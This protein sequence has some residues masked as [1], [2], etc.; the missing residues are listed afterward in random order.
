MPLKTSSCKRAALR[1]DMTRFS[2]V[3]LGY[4]LLLGLVLILIV[5]GTDMD[6]WFYTN[7]A[8]SVMIMAVINCGYAFVTAQMLFGD[9]FNTRLCYG[10]H[11]LPLKREHWY[12]AHKKAGM[13]FSL[14]PTAL[15]TLASLGLCQAATG[16]VN[17]WQI[18][19][20]WFAA[21]NLQYL[22]FFG[23]A[24]FCA[25]CVGNRFAM[26]VVYAVIN[27][28]SVLAMLLVDSLY[29]PMLFGVVTP[30][31]IFLT[32]CPV[33][34]MGGVR[35]SRLLNT[36]RVY[37]GNTFVDEFGAVQQ[38]RIGV[39]QLNEAGW[40]YL[41]IAAVVGILLLLIARG[42]YRKRN[43]ECAGDFSAI[44][45]LEPVFLLI[46]ALAGAAGLNG[47]VYLFFGSNTAIYMTALGLACG[48]F[49]G[50]MFIK[51]STRVIT[52]KSVLGCVLL[53]AVLAG[54]LYVTSLDPLGIET[55]IPNPSQIQTVTLRG[56]YNAQVEAER[57]DPVLPDIRLIH[58]LALEERIPYNTMAQDT[59]PKTTSITLVY[60]LNNG[61]TMER[62]Y[63]VSVEG[64][65]GKILKDQFSDF[66]NLAKFN[67]SLKNLKE[68]EDVVKA[69]RDVNY[70]SV[71]GYVVPDE[72]NTPE[73]AEA[74]IRAVQADCQA[75]TMAQMQEYHPEPLAQWGEASWWQYFFEITDAEGGYFQCYVYA[76]AAN[77]RALLEQTG[78]PQK[79]LEERSTR[80][81]G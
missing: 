56:S 48:W 15:M 9:L 70:I 77:T 41:A 27:F 73:F 1:K 19:L 29:T 72:Y 12:S 33:V 40:Q 17:G 24:V 22:F 18:P 13:L 37:T 23:I 76:D 2:P 14:I 81:G 44:R 7:M 57:E 5:D 67:S 69:F 11:A 79:L 61:Y 3:W 53:G 55:R 6:Y 66:M 16:M 52:V 34:Q 8:E 50:L 62:Q 71:D 46:M 25:M 49:A 68:P 51:R 47:L 38:E 28:G 35:E 21:V 42:M 80:F 60:T 74:L 10:L 75:G 78:I 4:L 36:E 63:S 43:L 26:A 20:Y 59:D 32:F 45:A 58:A 54:S 39:F 64:E 65:A 30:A 31:D